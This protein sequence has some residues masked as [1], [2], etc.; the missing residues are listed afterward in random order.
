MDVGGGGLCCVGKTV[1]GVHTSMA[2]HPEMPL[3]SLFHLVHFGIPLL[4]RILGETGRADQRG[5]HNAAATHHPACPLQAVFDCV[6]KQLDQPLRL[7]QTSE[8][9]QGRGIWDILLKKIDPHE[10]PHGVA[11]VN[12]VLHSLVEQIEPTLQ[13]IHP[14]HHPDPD[15]Q[16]AAL[17]T[18]VVGHDQR[19]PFVPWDDLVHDFQEFFPLCFLL[20]A[21]VLHIAEAFPLY[22]ICLLNQSAY[23]LFAPSSV[24]PV[25]MSPCR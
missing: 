5:I 11:V 8:V 24:A 12:G 2:L 14:Q 1:A 19:Y 7:Q 18:G 17:S 15:W 9:R 20:P 22:F 21:T 4:F 10:F 13:Q 6:K 23:F 25:Q 3:I 16:M